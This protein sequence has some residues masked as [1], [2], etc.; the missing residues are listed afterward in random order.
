MSYMEVILKLV[1]T[2]VNVD[3]SF[4][5]NTAGGFDLILRKELFRD[6]VYTIKDDTFKTIP[7]DT[8]SKEVFY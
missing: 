6:A 7:F 4:L 2:G 8:L 3:T 5:C 1:L